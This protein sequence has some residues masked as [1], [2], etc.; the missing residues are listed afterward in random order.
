MQRIINSYRGLDMMVE[1]PNRVLEMGQSTDLS[2]AALARKAA[3]IA[4]AS[5]GRHLKTGTI[6]IPGI[7]S[8]LGGQLFDALSPLKA[9]EL[10]FDMMR[11]PALFREIVNPP[12]TTLSQKIAAQHAAIAPYI[13]A[14]PAILTTRAM[15]QPGPETQNRAGFEYLPMEMQP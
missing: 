14:A 13:S 7:F 11:D 15:Q 5:F 9:R 4:G 6:Q 10:Q 8:Q 12:G 1:E 3:N 2:L